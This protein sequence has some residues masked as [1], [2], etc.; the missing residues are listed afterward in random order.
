MNPKVSIVGAP[1]AAIKMPDFLAALDDLI[2]SRRGGYICVADVHS[3]MRARSDPRHAK[4]LR[5][6][7]LVTPDG[8]PLVWAAKLKGVKTI[9]RVCGPDLLEQVCRA[10]TQ[11]GWKHY[12]Y[13]GADGVS[14]RLATILQ[15][16]FPGLQVVG[17]E[18]PPFRALTA[19]EK[20]STTG[21]MNKAAPDVIWVGLGCPKQEQWMLENS[22][23]LPNAILIGIGAAFDFHTGDV[24]RAPIWM[25]SLGLEWLHRLISE[26]RRLWRRYLVLAPQFIWLSL[27]EALSPNATA[28]THLT[29]A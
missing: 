9:G 23:R 10:S 13:G 7:L 28:Q 15:E 3:V 4:A 27:S 18:S 11:S 1:V 12:F 6:A 5:D 17:A 24:K 21:R 22:R 14:A 8:M 19:E 25:R 16:R 2:N 26:P 29:E 20:E